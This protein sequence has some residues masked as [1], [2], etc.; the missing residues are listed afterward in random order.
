MLPS[1]FGLTQ[2]F[3][4]LQ[5][6]SK[7]EIDTDK[8][9]NT[10]PQASQ[11]QQQQHNREQTKKTADNHAECFIISNCQTDDIMS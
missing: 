1:K 8:F 4:Y 5:Q 9:T 7:I 2:P 11:Q 3:V 10:R 6:T